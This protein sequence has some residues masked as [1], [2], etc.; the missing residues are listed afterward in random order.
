MDGLGELG[1]LVER[2]QSFGE[3]LF[4]LR[5]SRGSQF[6]FIADRLLIRALFGAFAALSCPVTAVCKLI[7]R[8]DR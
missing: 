6:Q 8:H 4:A 3:P 2:G 7:G 5:Q 1:P